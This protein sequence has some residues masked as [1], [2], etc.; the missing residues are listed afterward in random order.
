MG[1][2]GEDGPGD[3]RRE[4]RRVAECLDD[5]LAGNMPPSETG[6]GNDSLAAL[7]YLAIAAGS[8]QP[9]NELAA[10]AR[11]AFDAEV[12]DGVTSCLVNP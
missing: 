4:T 2:H 7:E 10:A 11:A 1:G 8:G 9:T 5:A 3:A 12:V 6:L